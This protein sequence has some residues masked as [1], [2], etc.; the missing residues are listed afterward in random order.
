[1]TG[2]QVIQRMI[3]L[4]EE[5]AASQSALVS[6]AATAITAI[7]IVVLFAA[8]ARIEWPRST[9]LSFFFSLEKWPAATIGALAVFSATFPFARFADDPLVPKIILVIII[10]SG[11]WAFLRLVSVLRGMVYAWYPVDKEDNL[12]ERK[13]RTQFQYIR[14]ILTFSILFVGF[15]A[16]FYQFESLRTLG[17][18]LLA[19]AGVI[20][21]VIAF[22]AHQTLGNLLAGFQIAFAQPFRIDDVVIVEG[23]WGKIEEITFTYV[24]VRIWDQRRL[25]LPISYFI[26]NPFQNW[27]RTNAEIMGTVILYLD[28]SVPLGEVR[29]ELGRIVSSSPLWD[30]RVVGLQV[31]DSTEK[32]ITLRALVSARDASDAWDLR[33]EVREQ[34][35]TF[36]Q[37]KHPDALPRL[38]V[39]ETG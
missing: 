17:T 20:G 33:C 16:I 5:I 11:M 25:V 30:G 27:T 18:G 37:Q 22:A 36:L 21:V 28:Y 29:E 7:A 26:N 12:M 23:E 8:M 1:M 14:Y 9:L 3:P 10:L 13:V 24:V 19:S 6:I 39:E 38:R 15:A 2:E 35:I 4:I 31:T 34:L 32:T